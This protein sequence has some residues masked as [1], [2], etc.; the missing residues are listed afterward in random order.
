[1]FLIPNFDLSGKTGKAAKKY[2][3]FWFFYAT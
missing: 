2:D 1:M 3:K